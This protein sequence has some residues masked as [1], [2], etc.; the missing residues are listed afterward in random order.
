[1]AT[2]SGETPKPPGQHM[3]NTGLVAGKFAP[4]HKG[5]ELVLTTAQQQCK[6]LVVL[7]YSNPDFPTMPNAVRAEWIRKLYPNLEVIVPHNPPPNTASDEVHQ[8]FL[9]RWLLAND[10]HV[11]AQF[12]SDAYLAGSAAYIGAIPVVVDAVRASVPISGTQL[13]ANPR[14]WPDFLSPLVR[15]HL[16]FWAQPIHTVVFLGAEST[17]K[18]TLTAQ[19][20]KQ[21]RTNAVPEYGREVWEQKNGRLSGEDYV[22]IAKI[23]RQLEDNA[24]NTANRFLFIDTNAIT[25][26]F[27]AYAY[28]GHAPEELT[29]LAKQAETRYHHIFLC[30]DD[31]PFVQDGWRDDAI[32]RSRAQGMVRYDLAVRGIA[33][34]EVTGSLEQRVAQVKAVLEGAVSDTQ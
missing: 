11:D 28:A 27:L 29:E 14:D 13:R 34:T 19:M 20:A 10:I 33:Y 21:Y 18:T 2:A 31:I 4:F 15:R 25:T 6:R 24:R 3:Y 8:E 30:A 16:E 23:H 12:G 7:C 17:G 22:Y 32:W 5:H 9:R 1:M 26:M